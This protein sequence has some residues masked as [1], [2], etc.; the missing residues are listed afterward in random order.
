MNEKNPHLFLVR[1][2]SLGRTIMAVM[3][4]KMKYC[5]LNILFKKNTLFLSCRDTKLSKE[6]GLLTKSLSHNIFPEN[7]DKEGSPTIEISAI[8]RS[9]IAQIA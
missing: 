2:G 7:G 1:Y 6:K 4:S 8:I 9:D 5:I 3:T